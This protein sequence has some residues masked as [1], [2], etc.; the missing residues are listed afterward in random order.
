LEAYDAGLLDEG[1]DSIQNNIPAVKHYL[2]YSGAHL[3]EALC[4]K[5]EG[6]SPIGVIEIFH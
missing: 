1:I 5:P 6:S 2:G 4:Y 3:F